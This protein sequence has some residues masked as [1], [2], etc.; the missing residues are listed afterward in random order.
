M[1]KFEEEIRENILEILVSNTG[2][3]LYGQSYLNY[4]AVVELS[5]GWISPEDHQAEIAKLNSKIDWLHG[6]LDEK[7]EEVLQ[8]VKRLNEA[9]SE[10]PEVP[11]F[12]DEWLKSDNLEDL[13]DVW[14][15]HTADLPENVKDY[16]DSLGEDITT[17]EYCYKEIVH[18]IAR[19]KLDG[20]TVE[21]PKVIVSPCPVC[22]FEDVEENFCGI[23]GHKNEYVEVAKEKR[24][25]LKHKS[26][27][28]YEGEAEVPDVDELYLNAD[29]NFVIYA[30]DAKQFTQKEIDSME[31]GSYE[32]IEVVE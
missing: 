8:T 7:N 16:L 5:E 9:Q 4:D 19:A 18:L 6:L 27:V 26:V 22:G 12:M 32:Q 28:V 10:I 23:C 25:Y 21:T 17:S 29:G 30:Y 1:K 14:Y 20:Y 3:S 24:F 11:Q 31:T 13:I 2:S 15:N